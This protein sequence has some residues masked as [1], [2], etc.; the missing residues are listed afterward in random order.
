MSNPFKNRAVPLSGPALDLVPITPDDNAS[1][2]EMGVAFYAT[3]GGNVALVTASG[4]S[5]TVAVA[6]YMLVPLGVSKILQTGTT[7]SGIHVF[8]LS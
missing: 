6:D 3:T 2:P 1:F 4:A 8:T 5:R 7:A